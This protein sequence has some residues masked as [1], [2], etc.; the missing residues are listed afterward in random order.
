MQLSVIVV[1]LV[2][3]LAACRPTAGEQVVF[4][5]EHGAAK[6]VVAA[7]YFNK[8]A[9]ERGLPMKAVARGATPQVGIANSAIK[10]LHADGLVPGLEAPRALTAED[11]RRSAQVVTFDCD[12]PAMKALQGMGACWGDVPAVGEDYG[13]ARN[14]IR[15]HLEALVKQMASSRK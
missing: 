13:R 5:C 7:A 6:S 14:I 9:A 15:Q 8:L 12:Q 3:G 1:S 2:G 4:V 10:G 11:V